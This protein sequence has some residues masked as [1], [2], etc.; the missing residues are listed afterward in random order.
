MDRLPAGPFHYRMLAMIGAGMF[1]DGFDIYILAG[2]IVA[3]QKMGWAT[4]E[5]VGLVLAVTVLGAFLGSLIGGALSD[6]FGRKTMYKTNLLIYGLGSL[7]CALAPNYAILLALRLISGLGMGAQIPTGYAT[8]GE[9]VPPHTRGKF[10]GALA[11]I[12]NLSQP[13]ALGITALLIPLGGWRWVFVI[14]AL[15]ALLVWWVQRSMPESPRWLEASGRHDE[16]DRMVEAIERAAEAKSGPLPPVN[17]PQTAPQQLEKLPFSRLFSR[18]LLRRTVFSCLIAIVVNLAIYGFTSW[19]PTMLVKE[20]LTVAK[21]L[22]FS[23]IMLVGAPLGVLLA[24]LLIDSIGRRPALILYTTASSLAGYGYAFVSN[25]TGILVLGFLLVF[26]IYAA[27][28]MTF[29]TY[30]PELF[31]TSLRVSGT[32]FAMALGRLSVI[33]FT[34]VVGHILGAQGAQ[35]VIITIASILLLGAVITLILGEET[36]GKTLEEISS[37]ISCSK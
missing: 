29:S 3:L 25:K 11:L 22:V 1:F 21:S 28:A 34:L 9:L 16:A 35:V 14:G 24:L 32:G 27:M 37:G 8:F 10:G 4:V 33:F 18:S 5:S 13:A 12:T 15:P 36:K 19:L 23:T 26:F 31:P 2:I 6:K 20:G 30:V 17:L 7:G